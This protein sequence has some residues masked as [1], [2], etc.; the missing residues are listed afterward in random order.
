MTNNRFDFLLFAFQYIKCLKKCD[1]NDINELYY[2]H[3]LFIWTKLLINSNFITIHPSGEKIKT[4][5]NDLGPFD[6]FN[7][8]NVEIIHDTNDDIIHD[9]NDKIIHDMSLQVQLKQKKFTENESLMK[10]HKKLHN[11][12]LI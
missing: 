5:T 12:K 9:M 8:Y 3:Y 2:G 1:K 11:V 4:K 10:S 6:N 7:E